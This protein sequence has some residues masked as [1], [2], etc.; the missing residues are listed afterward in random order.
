MEI[1]KIAI[2]TLALYF[3]G[4]I[5]SHV[6]IGILKKTKEERLSREP[7]NEELKINYKRL[8]V[9][10]KWFPAMY[11]VFILIFLYFLA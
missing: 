10:F 2:S 8:T 9:L 11:V 4:Y 1:E 6:I 3:M 5:I 7:D